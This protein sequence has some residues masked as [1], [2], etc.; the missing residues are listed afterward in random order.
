MTEKKGDF[1]G[2]VKRLEQ[3]LKIRFRGHEHV[4]PALDHTPQSKQPDAKEVVNYQ[5]LEF[6]GDAILNFAVCEK[7]FT[8]FPDA[9]EG[10]L[11][12]LRSTLVSKKVLARIAQKLSLERFVQ[13]EAERLAHP[14]AHPKLLADTLEALIGAIY[15]DR[16][17]KSVREFIWRHWHGYFDAGKLKRLDPNPKSSLQEYAQKHF[18]TLPAYQTEP[19]GKGFA[20]KVHA[21][22]KMVGRGT[23]FS[24]KEAEEKAALELLRKIRAK[25]MARS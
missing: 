16:G 15:L 11:S 9:D 4:I 2:R 21:G 18:G 20:S 19:H 25:K 8:L 12:R 24:K 5:R 22:K 10:L 13:V 6:F 23:G 17:L 1:S 7:I 14:S 3:I